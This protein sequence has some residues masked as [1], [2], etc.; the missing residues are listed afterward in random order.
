MSGIYWYEPVTLL[1]FLICPCFGA[2]EIIYLELLLNFDSELNLLVIISSSSVFNDES[3][4][5]GLI[6]MRL[7]ENWASK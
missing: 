5:I 2:L 7:S 4:E 1:K 3:F 6:C